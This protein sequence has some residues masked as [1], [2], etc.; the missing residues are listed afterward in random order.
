MLKLDLIN[1]IADIYQYWIT[2]V[3]SSMIAIW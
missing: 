2:N 3:T 1:K